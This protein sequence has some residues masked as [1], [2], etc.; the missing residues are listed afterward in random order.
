MQAVPQ[1]ASQL[2]PLMAWHERFVLTPD[3]PDWGRRMEQALSQFLQKQ[4]AFMRL[5]VTSIS[6]RSEH[7]EVQVL[8]E[9][10]DRRSPADE[11][12]MMPPASL[13]VDYPVGPLLRQQAAIRMGL[14]DRSGMILMYMRVRQEGETTSP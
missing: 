1:A 10:S 9:M 14:G 7:C 8:G 4:S 13:V 12:L 3:D 2:R 11:G 6:C 5:E